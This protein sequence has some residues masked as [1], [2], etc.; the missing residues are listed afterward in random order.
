MK[1]HFDIFKISKWNF[2]RTSCGCRDKSVD[3]ET[4]PYGD[5]FELSKTSK[6]RKNPENMNFAI[7][8]FYV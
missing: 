5:K 4:S 3:V 8:E 2:I 1:F 6:A 7:D